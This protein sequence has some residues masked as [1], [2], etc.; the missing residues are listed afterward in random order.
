MSIYNFRVFT[1]KRSPPPILA[2]G[3]FKEAFNA[4][5]E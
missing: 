2:D 1:Q 3:H 5:I 4:A